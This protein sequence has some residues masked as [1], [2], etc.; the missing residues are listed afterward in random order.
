M[1]PLR[2]VDNLAGRDGKALKPRVTPPDSQ[3][4]DEAIGTAYVDTETTVSSPFKPIEF[5][6]GVFTELPAGVKLHQLAA[7]HPN[8]LYSDFKREICNETGRPNRMP[9]TVVT[10]DSSRSNFASAKLDHFGYRS[11]ITV[12]RNF[13]AIDHLEKVFAEFVREGTLAGI[14]PDGVDVMKLRRLWIWP[15]WTSMDKDQAS[16]DDIR[17]KNG[18]LTRARYNLE[19]GRDPVAEERQ[20]VKE[21][22]IYGPPDP[23]LDPPAA[24]PEP[25]DDDENADEE[26]QARAYRLNGFAQ[27]GR[28]RSA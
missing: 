25:D 14:F 2:S 19:Q 4:A 6:R 22:K 10:A 28:S 12:D 1:P 16:Q 18:T 15:G 3:H 13:C 11:A 23:Q 26:A 21:Q 27:S 9:S 17:L 24:N 8:Q 20:W 5:D 7:E